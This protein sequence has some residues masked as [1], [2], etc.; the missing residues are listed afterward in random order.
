MS[1]L[2]R[3]PG[4]Q[5]EA[6]SP[7]S[8]FCAN[9]KANLRRHGDA[10]QTAVTA[11]HLKP[12]LAAV[13]ARIKKN[14]DSPAWGEL[15]GRWL[16][17]VDHARGVITAFHSGKA[18]SRDQRKA[19]HEVLKIA[20]AA[21]PWQVMEIVLAM[22]VMEGHDPRRFRSDTAFR[23]Q[24]VRRARALADVNAGLRYDHRSG[25]VRRVYRELTPSAVRIIG[26]WLADASGGAGV[27]LAMLE[28]ADAER[29]KAERRQ[30]HAA[31]AAL[32]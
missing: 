20:D 5:S 19:A 3:A 10:T 2:C 21:E 7:Y 26:Q 28:H 17:V 11:A 31:L 22:F 14:K 24:L 15:E 12:H 4:C 8:R 16:T 1:Y 13:R 27:R 32:K 30:F 18:G 6:S 9:H 25:K 23:F 29:Q